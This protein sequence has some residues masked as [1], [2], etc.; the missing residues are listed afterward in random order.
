[1]TYAWYGHLKD[2]ASRPLLTVIFLSWGVAFFEYCL[3]VPANRMGAQL[4]SVPQLK[5]LQE[6]LALLV[7]AIF[8]RFYWQGHLS[9]HF[10]AA[11]VLVLAAVAL[12]FQA[13]EL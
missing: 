8:Y 2:F 12:V 11:S 1:M 9:W 3:Q 13:V 10:A 4:A 7:F 5:I 6:A